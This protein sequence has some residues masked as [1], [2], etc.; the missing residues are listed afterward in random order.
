MG[1]HKAIVLG[2]TLVL[3]Y[4]VLQLSSFQEVGPLHRASFLAAISDIGRQFLPHRHEGA[5]RGQELCNHSGLLACIR[6]NPQGWL[7]EV[8]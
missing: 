4:I 5:A 2:N 8:G 3:Q 1:Q 6:G 7:R